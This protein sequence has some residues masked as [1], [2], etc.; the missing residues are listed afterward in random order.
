MAQHVVKCP[1]C[2][3]SNLP[4]QEFCQ[5][6]QA[7]LQPL[8]GKLKGADRPLTP[9]DL[10]TKKDTAELEPILPQWLREARSSARQTTEEDAT[11]DIQQKPEPLT[12]PATPVSDLLAGLQSQAED[13]EEDTPDWLANITGEKTKT[14]KPQAESSEVRWVELGGTN[15]FAQSEPASDTPAWLQGLTPPTTPQPEEKDELTSWM[16][17]ADDSKQQPS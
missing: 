13:E 5:Y 10:P 15:D 8:T 16:R 2:G 9:G 4:D 3:E 11:Q 14:K 7:R 17:G 12:R 6:C 1:T